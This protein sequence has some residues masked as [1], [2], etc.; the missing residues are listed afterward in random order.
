[1]R[2]G[3][4]ALLRKTLGRRRGHGRVNPIVHVRARLQHVVAFTAL[5]RLLRVCR[6]R[7]V[8]ELQ[9][10]RQLFHVHLVVDLP[11]KRPLV[12]LH[13]A[14]RLLLL[15]RPCRVA[16][17]FRKDPDELVIAEPAATP[18]RVQVL[19]Q[20]LVP[21]CLLGRVRQVG[22]VASGHRG[23][24]DDA[25]GALAP[26]LQELALVLDLVVELLRCAL[27][28]L[29][30]LLHLAQ[31]L[32]KLLAA[33]HVLGR[34]ERAPVRG[35]LRLLLRRGVCLLQRREWAS[36][37]GHPAELVVLP[38]QRLQPAQRGEL[39]EEGARTLLPAATRNGG[40]QRCAQRAPR[41]H[42]PAPSQPPPRG[43]LPLFHRRQCPK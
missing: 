3:C 4:R 22:G 30:V 17:W 16:K 13:C 19:A 6:G 41:Q 29:G 36:G 31:L 11:Q 39:C 37:R 18:Q 42:R 43:L 9:G 8:V 24:R 26:H 23:A 25:G 10:S 2:H 33:E 14:V 1:M 34:R 35:R 32:L 28:Q 5:R 15:G 7:L 21:R 27:G 20:H 40:P 38:V 12:G